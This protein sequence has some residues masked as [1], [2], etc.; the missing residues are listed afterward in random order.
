MAYSE[1]VRVSKHTRQ[2][3]EE[4]RARLVLE[5]GRLAEGIVSRTL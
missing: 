3:L 2:L 4:L 1:T 5:T